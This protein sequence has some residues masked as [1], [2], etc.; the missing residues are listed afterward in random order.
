MIDFELPR[1]RFRGTASMRGESVRKGA[2]V[3][4][5]YRNVD[6][7]R[8]VRADLDALVTAI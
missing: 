7:G 6:Q 3:G 4:R 2:E 8:L 1:G 5:C